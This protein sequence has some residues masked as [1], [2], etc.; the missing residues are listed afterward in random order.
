MRILAGQGSKKHGILL[1]VAQ[2]VAY[3]LGIDLELVSVKPSNNLT[4]PNNANTAASITSELCTY[5]C[6]IISNLQS[7]F[8]FML[9]MYVVILHKFHT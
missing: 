9:L 8:H 6:I 4:A 5:V 2:A 1:Q 7:R 3:T